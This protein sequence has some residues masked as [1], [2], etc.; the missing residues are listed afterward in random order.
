MRFIDSL[1]AN[2]T[3]SLLRDIADRKPSELDFWNGSVVRQGQAVDVS[4]P[5]NEF[6]YHSMLPQE[7]RARGKIVFP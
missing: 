6:V 1:A 2:A 3:T 5:V 4:T 7:L